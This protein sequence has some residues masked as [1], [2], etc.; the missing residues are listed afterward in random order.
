MREYIAGVGVKCG[1]KMRERGNNVWGQGQ[2][3]QA[4]KL[5]QARQKLVFPSI[6]DILL[7]SYTM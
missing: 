7:S 1:R 6:F 2:S 4:I 3:G 5:F